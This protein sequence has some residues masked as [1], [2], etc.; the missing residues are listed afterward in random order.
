MMAV[1]HK[2]GWI[3]LSPGSCSW[4]RFT[5]YTSI[6]PR[7]SMSGLAS[8]VT[9]RPARFSGSSSSGVLPLSKGC[10]RLASHDFEASAEVD[11]LLLGAGQQGGR[12]RH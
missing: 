7:Q 5:S 11:G 1:Y 4:S 3:T 12:A 2:L 9:G 6:S 8:I 10:A